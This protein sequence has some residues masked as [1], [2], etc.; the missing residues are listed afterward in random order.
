MKQKTHNLR[1]AGAAAISLVLALPAAAADYTLRMQ[2]IFSAESTPGQVIRKFIDDLDVM[3]DGRVEVQMH[4]ASELV[5]YNEEQGAT[6]Q[7]VL[8]CYFSGAGNPGKDPGFQFV[9]DVTGGYETPYQLLAW[10]YHGG[11]HPVVRDLYSEYGL[12]M[13]G[14]VV[15]G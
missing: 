2:T 8:D 3:S 4:Y 11:G 15:Q 14:F 6:A 9:G 7:G 13:I 1:L 10:L 5:A 12:H